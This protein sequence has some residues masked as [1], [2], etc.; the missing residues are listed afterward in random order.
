MK[1]L[2]L[3]MYNPNAVQ[4]H[5]AR[6]YD[7]VEVITQGMIYLTKIFVFSEG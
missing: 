4:H 1:G 6:I 5:L 3:L 7:P 2:N